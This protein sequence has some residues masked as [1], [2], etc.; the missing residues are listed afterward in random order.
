MTRTRS[1][2]ITALGTS[3]TEPALL[4]TTSWPSAVAMKSASRAVPFGAVG[5]RRDGAEEARCPGTGLV[6]TE[7]HGRTGLG[8]RHE[9]RWCRICGGGHLTGDQRFAD[10]QGARVDARLLGSQLLDVVLAEALLEP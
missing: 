4:W 5:G 9:L 3:R 2:V 1:L 8:G 10:R 6:N 7:V